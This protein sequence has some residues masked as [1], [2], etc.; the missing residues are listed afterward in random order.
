LAL[1]VKICTVDSG[2]W[3]IANTLYLI[4]MFNIFSFLFLFFFSMKW[5]VRYTVRNRVIHTVRR[6]VKVY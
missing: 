4:I 1:A 6:K 3:K 5:S 2:T